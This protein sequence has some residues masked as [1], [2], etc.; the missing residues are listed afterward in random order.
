MDIR[1]VFMGSPEFAVP[2][3]EGLAHRFK[4]VGVV[5][6]PDRPSGRGRKISLPPVKILALELNIPVIQPI[7]LR[8][9]LRAKGIIRSWN[10]TLIVVTAFGQILQKDVLEMASLGCLNVHAS[11]LPRWRGPS[12]IQAAILNGDEITGVTIMKMDEGIDTGEILRQRSMKIEPE[13]TGDSLSR[14]LSKLGSGLLIETIPAYLNGEVQPFPQG[15]TPT[16][17]APILKKSD[18]LLDFSKP[19]KIL[20]RKVRAYH[21]WPGTYTYWKK[22]TLKIIKTY[23]AETK[24]SSIGKCTVFDDLPA[25]GTAEG[26]LVIEELQ[27]AGKKQVSGDQFLIGARDWRESRS[28]NIPNTHHVNS[29]G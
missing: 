25:I 11:L 16:P 1:I 10:P 4:V 26:L 2:I 12:P 22:K 8:S 13:D 29:G 18:G 19:A 3:F 6:Q 15:D 21:P 28:G 9:D 23:V 24:S 17:Y 7:K 14:K 5:T 27:L 20:A